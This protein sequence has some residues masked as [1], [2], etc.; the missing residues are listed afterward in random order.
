MLSSRKGSRNVNAQFQ[1]KRG[2]STKILI[3]TDFYVPVINGVVTSILTLQNELQEQGHEVRVLTLSDDSH[4][5]S[6]K[7][8][9]TYI[10]SMSAAV[11]YPDA[12][13]A[14]RTKNKLVDELIEWHPDLIHSQSEFST[15][16][17]AFRISKELGIP[18]VHT[19]HTV[20]EEYTHYFSPSKKLGKAMI[21]IFIKKVLCCAQFVIA[22]T[23]KVRTMLIGYG[24]GQPILVVP[25]GVELR[26]FDISHDASNLQQLRERNGIPDGNRVVI[27]VGRLAKE[28]NLEEIISFMARLN[29]PDITLL[30]VGDGPHRSSLECYARKMKIAEQIIFTGMIAPDEVADY[31]RLGDVF[32]GASSSEAQGLTHME[33]LAAGVPALCKKDPCLD[34]VVMDG[35]NGWQ[36]SSYEHFSERL[37]AMLYQEKLREELSENA[38]T[39]MAQEYSSTAFANKVIQIYEKSLCICDYQ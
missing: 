30:V 19:Y 27:A 6:K 17:I 11:I 8:G 24:V 34:N 16:L 38:H 20:Y 29:N 39:G 23:D 9:V 32:V 3:T 26:K 25:T 37:N 7:D 4:S 22:P 28:K 33:A 18:I 14:L 13:I 36:Y 31:Y 1:A 21:T 35:V 12:R 2:Q 10:S 15:F 5:F